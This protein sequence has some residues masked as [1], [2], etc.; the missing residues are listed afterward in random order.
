[1]GCF[2]LG[3]AGERCC[4][5]HR[6]LRRG[7]AWFDQRWTGRTGAHLLHGGKNQVY[8]V[9]FQSDKNGPNILPSVYCCRLANNWCWF[10]DL[11]VIWK[12][13]WYPLSESKS[14]HKYKPRL[15]PLVKLRAVHCHL[16]TTKLLC[17]N[18]THPL[19]LYSGFLALLWPHARYELAAWGRCGAEKLQ[20]S[21]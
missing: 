6:C 8:V 21:L 18:I 2:E 12:I 5:L 20:L 16:N 11:L 14:T 15:A 13:T 10:Y 17:E 9:V 19:G 1:M 4:S 3:N 7:S